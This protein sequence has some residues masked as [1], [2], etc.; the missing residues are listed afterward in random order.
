M[1]ERQ[2]YAD[3]GAAISKLRGRVNI[4]GKVIEIAPN[5]LGIKLWGAVDY[6]CNKHKD[7]VNHG[8]RYRIA[9]TR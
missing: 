5:S 6:L 2:V 1:N 3:E 7:G 8:Y 9:R 4:S